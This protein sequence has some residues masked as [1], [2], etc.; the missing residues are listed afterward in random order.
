MTRNDEEGS[1]EEELAEGNKRRKT[2]EEMGGDFRFLMRDAIA[3]REA[4]QEIS[5]TLQRFPR[6]VIRNPE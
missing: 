2:R 3:K 6:R 4:L 1:R 5:D